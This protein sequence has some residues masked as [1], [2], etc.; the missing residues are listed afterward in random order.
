H[1][2][3]LQPDVQQAGPQRGARRLEWIKL[4]LKPLAN[5]L[6]PGE[7]KRLMC[8]L[9]LCTGVE[10]LLVFRDICGLSETEATK[11]GQWM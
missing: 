1:E 5:Q 7:R 9:A 11:V 8:A 3:V 4:A 2:T 10:A 6:A